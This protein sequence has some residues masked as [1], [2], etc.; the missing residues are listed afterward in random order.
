VLA[1]LLYVIIGGVAG[2][3]FKWIASLVELIFIFG[4]AGI[5]TGFKGS[6]DERME[7]HPKRF[8]FVV[9][10]K[11]VVVGTINVLMIYIITF[12]FMYSVHGNYWLYVIASIFWSFLLLG[13]TPAF[14]GM[15]F[16]TSTVSLI[17][18]WVGFSI[19]AP[20]IVA[21][22]TFF[23]SLAYYYGRINVVLENEQIRH[24]IS[25]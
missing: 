19:L 18:M 3:I 10:L 24:S 17:L 15:Y 12:N 5:L 20:M 7:L 14:I 25:S 21:P 13:Y 22:L 6:I 8:F 11:N 4:I 2:A 1:F 9:L 23:I 16:M